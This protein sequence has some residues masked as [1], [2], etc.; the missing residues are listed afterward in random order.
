MDQVYNGTAKM[1]RARSI[2]NR[3]RDNPEVPQ[4]TREAIR[5]HLCTN[6]EEL[7]SQKEL[8]LSEAIEANEFL[9]EFYLNGYRR[10]ENIRVIILNFMGNAVLAG[11]LIL[12][13]FPNVALNPSLQDR[14]FMY[15]VVVFGPSAPLSAG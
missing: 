14:R 7:K 12:W 8:E 5:E 11:V 2:L 4:R 15:L 3:I 9:H 1:T 6:S 10:T 13:I